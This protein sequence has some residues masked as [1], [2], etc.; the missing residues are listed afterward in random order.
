MRLRLRA[1][2]VQAPE[3]AAAFLD[4]RQTGG[5]TFRLQEGLYVARWPG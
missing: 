3:A 1:M 2:L 4:P 5:L